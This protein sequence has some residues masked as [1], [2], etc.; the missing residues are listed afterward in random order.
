MG[1][2]KKVEERMRSERMKVNEN[3]VKMV[4]KKR[5]KKESNQSIDMKGLALN[6]ER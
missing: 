2:I 5:R 4:Y 6:K 1:E 3:K